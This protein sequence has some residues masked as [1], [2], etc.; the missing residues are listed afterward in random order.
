MDLS[1]SDRAEWRSAR[2][3]YTPR[4]CQFALREAPAGRYRSRPDRI[5]ASPEDA[6]ALRCVAPGFHPA[7]LAQRNSSSRQRLYCARCHTKSEM[8]PT[9]AA[10]RPMQLDS[11]SLRRPQPPLQHTQHKISS[12]RQQRGGDCS[13]QNQLIVHHREPAKDEFA[14]A[15]SAHSRRDRCNSNREHRSDSYSGQHRR[16]RQRQL[17]LEENLPVRHPHSS[18]GFTHGA[19]YTRN[20]RRSVADNRKQRIKRK[21]RDRQSVGASP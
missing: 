15:A 2:F 8:P 10:E 21:R 11:I 17:Y 18:R 5:A 19:I 12:E 13:S 4:T 16:K 6:S 9:K 3:P 1:Q 20:S 14:Q 7:A